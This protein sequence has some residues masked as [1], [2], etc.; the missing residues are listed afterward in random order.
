MV[1]SIIFS[2]LIGGTFFGILACFAVYII[3]GKLP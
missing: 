2:V 1:G 3:G